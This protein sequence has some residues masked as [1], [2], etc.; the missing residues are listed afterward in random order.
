MNLLVQHLHASIK[1]S[2]VL[3]QE[4]CVNVNPFTP[5]NDQLQSS[6]FSLSPEILYIIQY[7]EF[8]NRYFAQMKEV[9]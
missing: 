8:G 9:D 2:E 4:P 3:Y 7:A 6:L 5:K 1:C